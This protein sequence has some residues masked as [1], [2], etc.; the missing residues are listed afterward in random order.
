MAAPAAVLVEDCP[1]VD[2]PHEAAP[3]APAVPAAAWLS[4]I[5]SLFRAKPTPERMLSARARAGL[6][7]RGET[8]SYEDPVAPVRQK[9]GEAWR[10]M[11]T[12]WTPSP[13]VVS[14]LFAILFLVS[15]LT[16]FLSA[17]SELT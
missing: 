2:P 7:H 14:A 11:F 15:A 8:F 9:S 4:Q 12:G 13:A 10:M 1:A 3:I 5:A 16:I 6:R 17:P